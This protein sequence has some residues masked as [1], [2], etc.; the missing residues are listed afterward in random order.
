MAREII[1]LG[2]PP[3]GT[4]GDTIRT[5]MDKCNINFKEIYDGFSSIPYHI[6]GLRVSRPSV[7]SI[8][9]SVGSAYIPSS[10][11]SIFLSSPITKTGI[12]V[13]ANTWLH[14]YLF[15]SSPGIIDVEWVTTAPSAPYSIT[16][17]TKN[18][19]PSRRYIGSVKSSTANNFYNFYHAVETGLVTYLENTATGP[20]LLV[21]GGV[22]TTTTAVS[23]SAIA[24]VSAHIAIVNVLNL[25]STAYV[26][27]SNSN[28][29][30]ASSGF[31][32]VC[33]PKTTTISPTPLNSSQQY[34]YAFDSSPS[35]ETY[36]RLFG[37]CFER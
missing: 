22:A 31:I 15:E 11:K 6:S 35:G 37:Y 3:N 28:G 33:A 4:D 27:L 2:T 13:A 26:N 18:G 14:G 21:A 17:R 20:F 16:A 7:N 25:S 24:P 8:A 1:N 9:V 36:H 30:S 10:G 32:T 12:S 29:P 34:T 5:A 23:A 19:D